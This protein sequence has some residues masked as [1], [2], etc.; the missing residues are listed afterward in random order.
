[1]PKRPGRFNERVWELGVGRWEFVAGVY[2][3]PATTPRTRA[4]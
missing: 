3:V 4:I 1:M 2:F